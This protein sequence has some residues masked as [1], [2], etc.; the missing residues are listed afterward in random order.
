MLHRPAAWTVVVVLATGCSA[1]TFVGPAGSRPSAPAA[2]A[3]ASAPASASPGASAAA[4]QAAAALNNVESYYQTLPQADPSAD[5]QAVA[6]HMVASGAFKTATVTPGGISATFPNGTPAFVFTDHLD[7]PAVLSGNAVERRDGLCVS[8]CPG[9]SLSPAT[10]HEIAF[11]VN[12]LDKSGAFVPSRQTAFGQAFVN[13]GFPQAGYGVDVLDASL[14]NI[15]ALGNGHPLDFLDLVTHGA[16]ATVK[17][18]PIYINL[19]TTPVTAAADITYASD[20][21]A[22]NLY[23]SLALGF[24][25]QTPSYAFTPAFM[26]EHLVFNPGAIFDNQSCHGQN[27]AIAA[28]VGNTLQTA[29]VGRYIGWSD[30]VVG[31][32]ADG[33]DAFMLDRSLGEQS[34]SVSGLNLYSRQRTPPQRPFPLDDIE[35]AMQTETRGVP[36]GGYP[37]TYTMSSDGAQLLFSD[38]GGE[39]VANPPI[40]YALPSIEYLTVTENGT[41]RLSIFG[42]FPAT[43]GTVSIANA[44]GMYSAPILNWTPQ[45]VDVSIP[46]E[47]DG[48]SGL[49]TVLTAAGIASN[50]VPLTQ[51]PGTIGYTS[52]ETIST[53]NGFSG[54]GTGSISAAFNF[55]FRSD[56]H[57]VVTTIDTTPAPQNLAFNDIESDSTGNVTSV[58][59]SFTPFAMGPLGPGAMGTFSLGPTDTMVAFPTSGRAQL[60]LIPIPTAPPAS[61]APAACNTG[62]YGPQSSAGNVSCRDFAFDDPTAIGCSDN[63][64]GQ[65]CH[66]PGGGYA[67][68]L[69]TTTAPF[70]G[71]QLA[72]DPTSYNVTVTVPAIPSRLGFGFYSSYP[73]SGQGTETS[74][75]TMSVGPPLSPPSGMTPAA[76]PRAPRN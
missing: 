63:V 28:A 61:P 23:Y 13:L 8:P 45:R 62:A 2:S 47:G 34:P 12:T 35:T 76:R 71:L 56:V 14:P 15:V 42:A 24:H 7:D 48:S 38:F 65:L 37:L 51:W 4:A 54:H 52:N 17:G 32:F 26:T 30:A 10:N 67:F 74:V 58:S 49:V 21:A 31:L 50:A 69:D 9:S 27:P 29:G 16:V 18:A 5:V 57:P 59:G 46:P 44:D 25:L 40:V 1:G 72:M 36:L 53:V 6:Q 39:S 33:S 68:D 3:P 64:G 70:G 22:G 43:A 20:L 66:P 60:G 19:S 11:L 41:A 75:L 55:H 73:D